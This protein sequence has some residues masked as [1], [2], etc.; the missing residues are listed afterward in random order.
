MGNPRTGSRHVAASSLA[1]WLA[2]AAAGCGDPRPLELDS[3]PGAQCVGCHGGTDNLT[4]APP[5]S[6]SGGTDTAL[7][8]VGAH[9][10]HVTAGPLANAFGCGECHPDPRTSPGRHMNRQLD[11]VFGPLATTAGATPAYSASDHGCRSTYC[12][13]AFP[14]GN[15]WNA[16]DWTRSG[17]GQADCGTC[18]AVPP[19][20]PHMAVETTAAACAGCH[21]QTVGANGA[22]LPGGAHVNGRKDAVQ[23]HGAGWTDA[24]SAGFHAYSANGGVS[25]C[26]GCHSAAG[27]TECHR[28]GGP[29]NDFARCTACH[30]GTDNSSG[31]PP[32][33]RW[34]G[35]TSTSSRGV[36]AHSSHAT[37]RLGGGAG[38]ALSAPFDCAAC[39]VAPASWTS[40]GHVDGSAQVTG[41]TG[42]D[43][44]LAAAVKDPGW[45]PA[46]GTCATAYCH[47]ATLQG[48]NRTIPSWT[49]VDG[50]QAACGTCHGRPPATG[51]DIGGRSGHEFHV[52]LQQVACSRCHHGFTA[53]AVD[54][55]LHV[56][57]IRDVVFQYG[58]P[59]PA[60]PDPVTACNS[61]IVL[62][63]R[64]S[65]WDCAGCH[66]YKD[67]WAN[68]CC[69][70]VACY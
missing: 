65:G 38:T 64:I 57:G 16:P 19:G 47:G 23:A 41:Y 2:L 12:H 59:D 21:P 44:A 49:T 69:E 60:I 58:I 1:A 70:I 20:P 22:I 35:E 48:G 61:P 68:A 8:G 53:T 17:Q 7:P 67:A 27:C 28:A 42:N 15:P 30:G 43:P 56:N 3:Q 40:T 6:R 14:G 33:T 39:H 24:A 5:A 13:G 45:S 62:T 10:A 51:S 52:S 63:A 54:A 37:G 4:G 26:L 18:H 46:A 31:A 9:T 50:T 25:S 29:A 34:P 32:R 66:A 55:A 11:L 36:G